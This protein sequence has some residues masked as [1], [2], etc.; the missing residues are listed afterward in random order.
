MFGI[1]TFVTSE[2]SDVLPMDVALVTVPVGA[3][4]PYLDHLAKAE[5]A[6]Y[7]ENPI[8][9][10]LAEAQWVAG[11]FPPHA[12]GCGFQRRLLSRDILVEDGC[13]GR[14]R[15]IRVAEGDVTRATG[16]N[17]SFRDDA[18]LSGGGILMDLG[19]H[20]LD[21]IQWITDATGVEILDQRLL[22]GG[23]IDRDVRLLL[24]YS[25]S[26]GEFEVEIDLSWVR[27]LGSFFS[28]E[29]E[30]ATVETSSAPSEDVSVVG[31]H[32]DVA[33]R[34]HSEQRMSRTVPEA[35]AEAWRC[36]LRGR[37][38][39]QP[40][41]LALASCFSTIELVERVYAKEEAR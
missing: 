17:S 4:D 20:A 32:G 16:V 41:A 30:E 10:T 3:R 2:P 22:F 36:F 11:L 13:F 39:R 19:V 33:W 5:T 15:R 28:I 34:L 25:S 29:F 37:D 27:P 12:V 9:R 35:V 40:G 23:R 14:V 18:S 24:C 26:V 1:H 7:L 21:L 6:V 31:R 8:A 38:T